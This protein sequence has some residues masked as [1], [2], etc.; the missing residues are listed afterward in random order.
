MTPKY[1]SRRSPVARA[2]NEF[3]Y[4]PVFRHT[5]FD[6]VNMWRYSLKLISRPLHSLFLSQRE[7]SVTPNF[8]DDHNPF[9]A[10]ES[11]LA[12]EIHR[13]PTDRLVYGGFWARF[14][15]VFLDGIILKVVAAAIGGGIDGALK[16]AGQNEKIAGAIVEIIILLVIQWLYYTLQESSDVGGTF[17]K[18][19]AGLRVVNLS[20]EKISFGQ[21]NGRYFAKL[22]SILSIGIGYL[23][24]P[25]TERRQALHDIIAGTLVVKVSK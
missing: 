16:D 13:E 19:A 18:R 23:I 25:F 9:A 11:D 22:L 10:P 3:C 6:T 4:E 20:G 12:P 14:G 15:A 7:V 24:Q 21:A 1:P 8:E 5:T 2:L 17:G